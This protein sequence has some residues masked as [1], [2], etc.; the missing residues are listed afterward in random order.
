[1]IELICISESVISNHP[2]IKFTFVVVSLNAA[3][4]VGVKTED[5]LTQWIEAIRGCASKSSV[6]M[7]MC[8]NSSCVEQ[9]AVIEVEGSLM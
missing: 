3:L 1:M 4:E 9:C 6:C 8:F 5:D 2:D 7:L